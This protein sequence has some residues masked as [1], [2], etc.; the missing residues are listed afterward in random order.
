M[1]LICCNY[2]DENGKIPV[3]DEDTQEIVK[4]FDTPEEALMFA[5]TEND[6]G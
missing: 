5:A 6:K 4:S 1:A 3:K 2:L